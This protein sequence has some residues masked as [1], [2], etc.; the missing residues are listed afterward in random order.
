MYFKQVRRIQSYLRQV[1]KDDA[2]RRSLQAFQQWNAIQNASGFQGPFALWWRNCGFRTAH[3]PC[4]LPSLPPDK[5]IAQAIFD[6]VLMA[7]RHL[8]ADLRKSSRQYARSRRAADPLLIFEDIKTGSAPG[9]DLFVEPLQA[10]VVECRAE[11]FSL[12]LDCPCPWDTTAPILHDGQPLPVIHAEGDQIWLD[13]LPNLPVNSKIAQVKCTGQTED[14]LQAFEDV[15]RARWNK[16]QAVPQS[17]WNDILQ[18]ARDHLP[19]RSST[20]E[21]LN[22]DSLAQC[23]RT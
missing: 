10:R 13:S 9:V 23:I 19:R 20:W 18:F 22:A 6:T 5:D 21:S 3:A 16:H 4:A 15:W 1:K 17:Q 2:N 11:D 14:I 8:E 7:L 12:I